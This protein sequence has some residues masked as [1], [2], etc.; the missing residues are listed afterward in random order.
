MNYEEA[1]EYIHSI[2]W[3]G[4]RPGLERITELCEKLGNPQE[5]LKFIHVAGTNGKGSV[6]AMLSS[7]LT[8]QGYKVGRFTSPYMKIF[9]ER[10]CINS[11]PIDNGSLARIT[12]EVYEIAEK[13]EDPPTEFELITAVGFLYFIEQN[14]DYVVLEVGMGGRLDSTNVITTCE[15]AVITTIGYDHTA[16]LGDELIKIAFEKAGIIK[17]HRPVVFSIADN[18]VNQIIRSR[19]LNCES[20]L[21]FAN[22]HKIKNL[23]MSLE[24]CTFSYEGYENVKIPLCGNYQPQNAAITLTAINTLKKQCGIKIDDSAVYKGLESVTWPGRFEVLNRRP[25]IIFDGAQG[26]TSAVSSIRYHFNSDVN[27]IFGVM[28]DKDY[29]EIAESI[30]TVAKN[31]Y[32][33]TPNNPRALNSKELSSSMRKIKINS[34]HFDS[35]KSAIEAALEDYE[36]TKAPIIALGSLYMYDEFTDTLDKVLNKN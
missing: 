20:E 35:I 9:N 16:Y 12:G 24:G 10:I 19:A 22:P 18:N 31:I 36:K 14:C 15:L 11:T 17:P 5:K 7:V 30:V 27:V 4:S 3:R 1:L 8:A 28:A 23:R 13:M 29:L 6:C 26:V 2:G 33:V 32:T 21:I 25:T 34:L